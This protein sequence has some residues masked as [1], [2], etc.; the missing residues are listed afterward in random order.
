M[1]F[2]ARIPE[3][4]IYQSQRLYAEYLP[5]VDVMRIEWVSSDFRSFNNL[6]NQKISHVAGNIGVKRPSF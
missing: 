3:I 2:P 6:P 1:L 4:G 5:F